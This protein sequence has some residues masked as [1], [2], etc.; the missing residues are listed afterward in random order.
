[1]STELFD[2]FE[3]PASAEGLINEISRIKAAVSD[4]VDD[5]V[6]SAMRAIKNGRHAAE[7][8]IDDTRRLVRRN[9]FQAMSI[10]FSVGIIAGCLIGW[11]STRRG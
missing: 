10:C 2:R 6:R 7:D 3:T 5:R 11:A 4:A 1:M 8:T 9:P